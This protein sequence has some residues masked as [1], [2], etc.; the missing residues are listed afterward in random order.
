MSDIRLINNTW[1][2]DGKR[3]QMKAFTDYGAGG[4]R[5]CLPAFPKHKRNRNSNHTAPVRNQVQLQE[6]KASS[7]FPPDPKK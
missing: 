7:A 4:I 5:L 6:I 2:V 1:D 3:Q